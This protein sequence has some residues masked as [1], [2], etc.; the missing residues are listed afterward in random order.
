MQSA[1]LAALL[2]AALSLLTLVQSSPSIPQSLQTTAIQTA[3]Q[4]LSL[5]TTQLS[6]GHDASQT[7]SSSGTSEIAFM[8][9]PASGVAPLTTTFSYPITDEVLTAS[10]DFEYVVSF[11]DGGWG[12]MTCP[13]ICQDSVGELFSIVHSYS[14]AG[15]YVATLQR[16]EVSPHGAIL[17]SST[18]AALTIVVN[19]SSGSSPQ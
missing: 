10:P 4:A 14:F 9:M 2:Q 7:S 13:D 17:S 8:A 11:G 15:T 12:E 1:S 3:E 5:V 19:A 6:I 18:V 16:E